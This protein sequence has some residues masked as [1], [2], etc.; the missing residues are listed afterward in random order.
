MRLRQAIRDELRAYLRD[1][2]I[3][4]APPAIEDSFAM[5][6]AAPPCATPQTICPTFAGHDAA[7]NKSAGARHAAK[8]RVFSETCVLPELD[9][10][11][12]TLDESF[13]QM[14]LRKIDEKGI[15]DSAV[16]KRAGIDRKLFSKIRSNPQYR[17][18]KSTVI[19]FI[20]ALELPYAEATDMLTKA[21][22]ALSHSSQSDVIVEYFI[23]R[24]LY[25]LRALNEALYE[26]D[27]ALI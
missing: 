3:P 24:G 18:K 13:Q 10:M 16:Y 4:E 6:E 27:Q 2:Y 9:Q 14:L 22:Y 25:D 1:H 11:L 21:G 12:V 8:A 26:Y 17:P 19:A 5:R 15:K 7:A 23:T 20:M